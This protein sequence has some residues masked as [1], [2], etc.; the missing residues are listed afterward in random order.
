MAEYRDGRDVDAAHS[1][2]P[3]LH[4]VRTLNGTAVTAAGP[5]DHPWHLGLSVALPDVDGTNFWGG[6]TYLL[7]RGYTWRD[8]HGHIEHVGFSEA[9]DRG[10]D[11]RLRWLTGTG[12]DLIGER[13]RIRARLVDHGWELAITTTLD[14]ATSRPLRLGSP[15]TNGRAGAGYG[16]L[17]WR[18]PHSPTPHVRTRSAVGEESAHGSVTPWL[19]WSDPT[20][21]LVFAAAD[22]DPWFVRVVDY[23]G[24]GLQLAAR[25]P[26]TLP[27][28]GAVTRGL[29]VLIADGALPDPAATAWATAGRARE[30]VL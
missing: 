3:Y 1:P 29:H 13:R 7:D 11:E 25:E 30:R 16:G 5:D 17:F 10:F 9:D 8:D 4:P 24:V 2:R 27:V 26:L 21:T 28:G 20:F 22:P 15:A 14:N 23:P 19:A 18:L 6:P 12:A